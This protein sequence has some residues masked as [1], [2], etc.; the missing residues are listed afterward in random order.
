M[1]RIKQSRIT[2]KKHIL[3]NKASEEFL[4]T[5][6]KQG[7]KYQKVPPHMH[8]PNAAEKAIST[9]KDHFKAIL[10][11]VDKNFPMHLW[12]RLLPQAEGTMNML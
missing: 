9:F 11:G 6:R 7:I 3:D 12:D 10:A 8:Q 2:I 4:Q 1:T 5:R